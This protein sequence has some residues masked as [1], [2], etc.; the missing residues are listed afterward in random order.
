MRGRAPHWSARRRRLA[1]TNDVRARRP[2]SL[3]LSIGFRLDAPPLARTEARPASQ[4]QSAT[5]TADGATEK[6]RWGRGAW[7]RRGAKRL[8]RQSV[9]QIARMAHDRAAAVVHLEGRQRDRREM[10]VTNRAKRNRA[11]RPR[12]V[13]LDARGQVK[14]AGRRQRAERDLDPRGARTARPIADQRQELP[15]V[16]IRYLVELI[17]RRFRQP[18]IKLDQHDARVMDVEVG[19]DW[20][21]ARDQRTALVH[22]VGPA[23]IVE[24]WRKRG[25]L[26]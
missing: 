11:G 20:R 4:N 5:G 16:A 8:D 19:P 26:G 6:P 21:V 10:D 13:E 24:I 12:A 2:A 23:A 14:A 18:G 15:K 17:D 1:W 22:E 7:L 9:M 3:A 25:H